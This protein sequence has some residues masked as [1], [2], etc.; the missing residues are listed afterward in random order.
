[1]CGELLH[2]VGERT[3][4]KSGRES[5]VQM[6]VSFKKFRDETKIEEESVL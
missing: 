6:D 3:A 2:R 5:G 4:D 1:M